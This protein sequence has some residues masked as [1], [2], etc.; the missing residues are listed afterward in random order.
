MLHKVLAEASDDEE[1]IVGLPNEDVAV[2][3]NMQ[4][5]NYHGIVKTNISIF[6]S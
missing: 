4:I 3:T 1:C 6:P 2:D 5:I